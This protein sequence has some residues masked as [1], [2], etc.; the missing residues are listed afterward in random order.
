VKNIAVRIKEKQNGDEAAQLS[1]AT[2][3][4]PLAVFQTG[5]RGNGLSPRIGLSIN[6]FSR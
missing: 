1:K 3:I 5:I 2:T 6:G 4:L